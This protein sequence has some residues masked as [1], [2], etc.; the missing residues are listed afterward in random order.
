MP[1][2]SEGIVWP[3]GKRFAFTI[4]DDPDGQTL[5][6]SREVYGFLADAGFRTTKCVWPVRGP[7]EPS[8][9][10]ATC[11]DPDY[12]LWAT[13]LQSSG[14][15]IALHNVTSHTSTREE[16][17]AGLEEFAKIFGQYPKMLAQHYFCD[18]N[19]YWAENRVS[20]YYR[21]LYNVLTR[22]NNRNKS[23]GHIA[24][25]PEFWADLCQQHIKYVR[26]FVFGAVN[27]LD[28]CPFM[29]YHDPQRP[30]VNYWFAASEGSN[31]ARFNAMMSEANQD[32]IEEEGGAC[33]I[34]THFG[35]GYCAPRLDPRFAELMKR[36]SR[37]GGWFV[38]A[39]TI[40]DHL[41]Q[42]K[43]DAAISEKQRRR[44]ERRW[45]L[46]KIHYGTA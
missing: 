45:L 29:P 27:T 24:G 4:V 25:H 42:R 20:G 19:I 40:L 9:F 37:R 14:F 23:H 12:R 16:T 33:I 39:S 7:R 6:H 26:N 22:F 18:E 28:A 5:E 46:H 17:K 35:H 11:A 8:D 10:G 34:Y 41:L 15:E 44:L 2:S 36:L 30:F 43:K 21:L 38:P 13:A 31:V 1:P 32:K 3:D